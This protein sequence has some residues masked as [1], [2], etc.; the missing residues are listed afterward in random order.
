VTATPAELKRAR[1]KIVSLAGGGDVLA[2][3]GAPF[4]WAPTTPAPAL[5]QGPQLSGPSG[6][7]NGYG[8]SEDVGLENV[9]EQLWNGRA[10]ALGW[11]LPGAVG[12]GPTNY[13][14][15]NP[16]SYDTTLANIMAD[17]STPNPQAW[18]GSGAAPP[19]NEPID[20]RIQATKAGLQGLGIDPRLA[21]LAPMTLTSND[22]LNKMKAGGYYG[23]PDYQPGAPAM[24]AAQPLSG[25]MPPAPP[26]PPA[27]SVVM[28]QR[29]WSVQS[30]VDQEGSMHEFLHAL[31]ASM[32]PQDR[33]MLSAIQQ[34]NP[35]PPA[36]N[37][38]HPGGITGYFDAWEGTHGAFQIPQAVKDFI[39]RKVAEI[40][41]PAHFANGG[42]ARI[43]M[44]RSMAIGGTASVGDP[45][46]PN[47]PRNQGFGS[48][49]YQA[50]PAPVVPHYNITPPNPYAYA[51]DPTQNQ[52]NAQQGV[53]DSR[54]NAIGASQG[55][56]NAQGGVLDARNNALGYS[57]GVINAQGQVLDAQGNVIPAQ[58]AYLDA[59]GNVINA[60]RGTIG[61]QQNY[62]GAQGQV[63]DARSAQN[64]GQTAY[65]GQAQG[66]NNQDLYEEQ[67]RQ[68]AHANTA[69]Q[70]A[71]AQ[72]QGVRDN[73]APIY[74]LAGLRAPREV[75]N[76]SGAPLPTGVESQ[77][78]TQEDI[79]TERSKQAQNIRNIKLAGAKLVVDLLGTN[80]N[81]AE[82]AAARIGLTVD[83][84]KL[85]VQQAQNEANQAQLGVSQ[86]QLGVTQAEL[87]K[88]Y[89]TNA[90]SQANLGT[91][92]AQ[93]ALGYANNTEAQANLG[94]SQAQLDLNRTQQPPAPGLVQYVNPSTGEGQW[95]TPA[96]ANQLEAANKP[97]TT[98]SLPQPKDTSGE[99][100]SG[101][102]AKLTVSELVS[103]YGSGQLGRYLALSA[104]LAKGYSAQAAEKLLAQED[105]KKAKSASGGGGI[106]LSGIKISP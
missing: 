92:Y 22:T 13:N 91:S 56:I 96:V 66:N 16:Q 12:G 19:L 1:M 55:V 60:Q 100:E 105:A 37:T 41:G 45:L 94:T 34:Q 51:G 9:P 29:E 84:A 71:V 39:N 23:D 52:W 98:G 67:Q 17:S 103:L 88:G 6:G 3:Q 43:G 21:D 99:T 33:Q 101:A 57:Q 93:N 106:D 46:D 24:V 31:E 25:N 14:K 61:P 30:A 20:T 36:F 58:Q 95:V 49:P 7:L 27:S 74:A 47:D 50:P 80:V 4:D 79:V 35:I 32:T 76:D 68:A 97:A 73:E 38:W 86:A 44:P 10:V 53:I 87:A 63:L 26:T 54:Q 85:L 2:G 8:P 89:A 5:P 62:I 75:I 78:R 70:T 40:R 18:I 65:L 72:A 83:Q 59:Q 69:D 11:Q 104:L 48:D 81:A 102:Y 82:I 64:Q 90:E 42:T 28:P 77:L 15:Y